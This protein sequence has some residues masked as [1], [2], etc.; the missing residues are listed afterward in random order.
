MSIRFSATFEAIGGSIFTV[1]VRFK[2]PRRGKL[3]GRLVI[4]LSNPSP[5]QDCSIVRDIRAVVGNDEDYR[6]LKAPSPYVRRPGM[7]W[8]PAFKILDGKRPP[9]LEKVPWVVKLE[10]F[11]IPEALK[12]AVNYGA[13]TQDVINSIIRSGHFP[14]NLSALTHTQRFSALLWI[15]E[16]RLK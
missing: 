6:L 4:T 7:S 3:R 14:G 8:R 9:V 2:Y 5:D 12:N 10:T 11:E 15:E 1:H 16:G 13:K